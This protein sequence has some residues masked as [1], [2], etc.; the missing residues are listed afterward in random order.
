MSVAKKEPAPP[1]RIELK[2]EDTVR[3]IAGKDRGKSG[4]V[5]RVDRE[6]GRILVEHVGMVKRH[7]RPNPSRQIKGGI[8]EREG[9]IAISNVMIVCPGCN[10]ATRIGHH[11]DQLPGGRTRRT[12][13]CLKCRQTLDKK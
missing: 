9:P 11:V 7:T 1:A 8:A 12:R 3:V 13:V 6:H 10:K 4:R 5:L 2:K